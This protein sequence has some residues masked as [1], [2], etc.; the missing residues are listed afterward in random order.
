MRTI[1]NKPA[2]SIKDLSFSRSSVPI[3]QNLNLQIN[4][5]EHVA[6]L[7]SNGSGKSTLLELI[8]GTLK[9]DSGMITLADKQIAFVPQRSAFNDS[10]PMTVRDT[11]EM[12]RWA[13]SGS[14]KRLTRDDRKIVDEQLNRL[15]ITE[16]QSKQ[17]SA[18]SGG[19]R[20]RTLIAQALSQEAPL[21]ML[22][23]PEA[24]L[25]ADAS[26]TI[27]DVLRQE[28]AK[29]VA[30]II[31]THDLGSAKNATRCVLLSRKEHGIVADGPPEE[32]LNDQIIAR[33][34]T[35]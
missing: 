6:L 34:F 31:A 27:N 15:G 4:Q 23:E 28:A 18:L 10:V 35:D 21:L 2:V 17:L 1:T 33:T 30:V 7:G 8:I 26:R 24:G 25:D 13:K 32:V 3:L 16:L 5:G 22:D 20:Q 11:V 19:Q 9:E 14:W 29:G 12:G